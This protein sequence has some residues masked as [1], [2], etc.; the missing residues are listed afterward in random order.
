MFKKGDRIRL[1]EPIGSHMQYYKNK[2]GVICK[3][4]D[5]EY[6]YGILMDG[7]ILSVGSEAQ[8]Y[9]P[10]SSLELVKPPVRTLWD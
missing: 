7:C 2:T 9:H 4:R 5:E 10:A 8:F 1:I 6:H 3:V